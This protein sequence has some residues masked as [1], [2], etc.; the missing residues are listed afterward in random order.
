MARFSVKNFFKGINTRI[1]KFR[2]GS[3]E[4]VNT[5]DVDLSTVELKPQAGLNSSDTTFNNVD[6]RFKGFD[7]TDSSSDKFTESGDLLIKSYPDADAKFDRVYYNSSG[8]KVGLVGQKDLGVPAKPATPT[9]T[10]VSTGGAGGTALG[11]SSFETSSYVNDTTAPT[12]DN[13]GV[14]TL[15]NDFIT[16][17]QYTIFERFGDILCLYDSVNKKLR[18]VDVTTGNAPAGVNSELTITNGDK[19]F[20]SGNYFIGLDANHENATIVEYDDN[21]ETVVSLGNTPPNPRAYNNLNYTPGFVNTLL[22]DV[23]VGVN[24]NHLFVGKNYSASYYTYQS[25]QLRYV[26]NNSARHYPRVTTR[27]D[28]PLAY[29]FAGWVDHFPN[30]YNS[31]ELSP[32]LDPADSFTTDEGW[33]LFANKYEFQTGAPNGGY[34]RFD[35]YN[36][37]GKGVMFFTINGVR[38]TCQIVTE[39]TYY[40]YASVSGWSY[41]TYYDT[42]GS[43]SSGV[44]QA[45][46]YRKDNRWATYILPLDTYS[47]TNNNT[48]GGSLS[49][50]PNPMTGVGSI[51]DQG[52]HNNGVHTDIPL[53]EATGDRVSNIPQSYKYYSG[54]Y[55]GPTLVNEQVAKNALAEVTVTGG[56]VTNVTITDGGRA[57]QVGDVF[58]I[59]TSAGIPFY[60]SFYSTNKHIGGSQGVFGVVTSISQ[61]IEIKVGTNSAL[62][63]D[64]NNGDGQVTSWSSGNWGMATNATT[65]L[66]IGFYRD[67]KQKYFGNITR[68]NLNSKA[69]TTKNFEDNVP[70]LPAH[71]SNFGALVDPASGWQAYESKYPVDN[72]RDGANYKPNRDNFLLQKK[73][74]DYT[75]NP[76]SFY[77][78]QSQYWQ[79]AYADTYLLPE[80]HSGFTS[81]TFNVT[82]SDV[83]K[84]GTASTD[85]T[86]YSGSGGIASG[87]YTFENIGAPATDDGIIYNPFSNQAVLVYRNV[88]SAGST[89]FGNIQANLT[90]SIGGYDKVTVD[91]YNIVY[92]NSGGTGDTISVID[93]Q[94][95]TQKSGTTHFG[96]AQNAKDAYREGNYSVIKVSNNQSYIIDNSNNNEV[97]PV[98]GNFDYT[99]KVGTSQKYAYGLLLASSGNAVY[100]KRQYFFFRHELLGLS[101]LHDNRNLTANNRSVN[102]VLEGYNGSTTTK[103]YTYLFTHDGGSDFETDNA[104]YFA[105]LDTIRTP[106]LVANLYTVGTFTTNSPG[107]GNIAWN[108]SNTLS[109]VNNESMHKV[110][111]G[112]R[113]TIGS[114]KYRVSNYPSNSALTVAHITGEPTQSASAS[115]ATQQFTADRYVHRN[116]YYVLSSTYSGLA[117]PSSLPTFNNAGGYTGID[118][119]ISFDGLGSTVKFI[120]HLSSASDAYTKSSTYYYA[121]SLDRNL[122]DTNN[123][124]IADDAFTY[125]GL[126]IYN[127]QGANIPFQYRIAYMRDVSHSSETDPFLIEGP[128]SDE[129]GS[130]TLNSVTQSI[131]LSGVSGI[132]N[133]V[134]KVRV[135]RVGGD[136]A[137]YYWLVDIDVSNNQIATYSDISLDVGSTAITPNLDTHPIPSKLS[138]IVNAN[139]FFI[140][141]K[142][143]KI[144]VSEYGN[145][146]SWPTSGEYDID[147]EITAIADSQGEAVVFT[148]NVIYRVRGFN[149]DEMTL[150]S[151][152]Q[153]QGVSNAKKYS[154]TKYLGALYFISND[155]LCEF[156]GSTIR[157]V[158]YGNFDKFPEINVPRG[159]F[160]DGVLYLFEGST[161]S[162]NKGVKVDFRTGSPVFSRISQKA[163]VRALYN[164]ENDTLYVK[165]S[166]ASGAYESDQHPVALTH[167]SGVISFGDLDSTKVLFKVTVKY[168]SNGTISE[169]GYIQLKDDTNSVFSTLSLPYTTGEYC[170]YFPLEAYRV[171]K[172]M[173]YI[174]TGKVTIYEIDFDFEQIESYANKMRFNYVDIQYTGDLKVDLYVDN[175]LQVSNPNYAT[176]GSTNL[177]SAS[178]STRTMRLHFPDNTYG[179][180]PHVYYTG[181]GRLLSYNYGTESL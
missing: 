118:E 47:Y 75:T 133:D 157:V 77:D 3:E 33:L 115:G 6:Y 116:R 2:I 136:Y 88:L 94:N 181:S 155:G 37:Y 150:Q 107:S 95:L 70:A 173:S 97:A 162:T 65:P 48:Y 21:T 175:A 28:R 148:D 74:Y 117:I 1:N 152:P 119:M 73:N 163:S 69:V 60:N 67:S 138:N 158:S 12:A 30:S 120:P 170:S 51:T 110:Q 63:L 165:D 144:Y 151:I 17:R 44:N 112:D 113:L 102:H 121:V 56:Q 147:G 111:I 172:Y 96:Y 80:T 79:W 36:T 76:A 100:L 19:V 52:D 114:G 23:S 83:Y 146:H 92:I 101:I 57:W 160:K 164:R 156:D 177:P 35:E 89:Q 4:A 140:G 81:S 58:E 179:Y 18:R 166:V 54:I 15:V 105:R 78:L 134:T 84:G 141:S 103:I 5:E 53:I 108:G 7:V 131:E 24:N 25:P 20:F 62:K 124:D 46:F 66:S 153:S 50:N 49:I 127:N 86:L 55:N 9:A 68:V 8:S 171:L 180:I 142:D 169:S 149:Y 34:W 13:S 126:S 99:A 14:T 129:S 26:N 123:T 90:L 109:Y 38:Y 45:Y 137:R 98:Y 154:L 29:I 40:Y 31:I 64:F 91:G 168:K 128:V 125:G 22:Q 42:V 72:R 39:L 43:A 82:S 161:Q 71:L 104:N 130:I 11:Y 61:E 174:V 85:E 139:G 132:P 143:S 178:G 87:W 59:P 176:T 32:S 93:L 135:Y 10:I 159:A 27:L 16:N 41:A 122:V 167:E 106:I 145:P